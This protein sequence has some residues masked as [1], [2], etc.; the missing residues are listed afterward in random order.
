[1]ESGF[2]VSEEL[3]LHFQAKVVE[4]T[5]RHW[6]FLVDAIKLEAANRAVLAAS[7][8]NRIHGLAEDVWALN[9]RAVPAL[10]I[11]VNHWPAMARNTHSLRRA[12]LKHILQAVGGFGHLH[13]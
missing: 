8:T 10:N 12:Q 11:L 13:G 2:I 6:V 5:V 1:M 3:L 7:T 9:S 4:F